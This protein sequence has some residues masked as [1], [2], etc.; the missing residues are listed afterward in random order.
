MIAEEKN[1]Y[2]SLTKATKYCSYSQE[3]LSL[4]ARQ[5]RLRA[6][7][8]GRN[9]VTKKEW[10]EEYATQAKNFLKKL[11][12]TKS[13]T[14]QLSGA[15]LDKEIFPPDNLPWGEFDVNKLYENTVKVPLLRFGFAFVFVIFLLIFGGL[16]EVVYLGKILSQTNS[17]V[18]EVGSAGERVAIVFVRKNINDAVSI[19][20]AFS[21]ITPKVV[22][23]ISITGRVIAK[24][25]AI[26]FQNVSK[27]ILSLNK[28]K[29]KFD[30][31][32]EKNVTSVREKTKNF[33]DKI[34]FL[35][36]T[37]INHIF[38]VAYNID[39]GFNNFFSFASIIKNYIGRETRRTILSGYKHN[40]AEVKNVISNARKAR[41]IFKQIIKRGYNSIKEISQFFTEKAEEN[42]EMID[43]AT[44]DIYCTWIENGEWKIIRGGCPDSNVNRSLR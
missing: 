20:N 32:I 12:I 40:S 28:F 39:R 26:E 13:Q 44:G 16:F 15:F 17:Y 36:Q 37:M 43:K 35:K 29:D 1:N 41:R 34:Y 10:V 42:R 9:W 23:E 25:T 24:E 27:I 8:F 11:N 18:E 6:I 31:N 21:A 3:Y 14:N 30:N 2:I 7:K 33:A 4:R 38:L 22:S 5:G 19:Y